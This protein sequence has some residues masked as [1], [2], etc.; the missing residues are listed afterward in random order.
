MT[1]PCAWELNCSFSTVR[2]M[3]P[4]NIQDIIMMINQAIADHLVTVTLMTPQFCRVGPIFQWSRGFICSL[5]MNPVSSCIL[6]GPGCSM[7]DKYHLIYKWRKLLLLR[8]WYTHIGELS[9]RY[10]MSSS[11]YRSPCS[12]LSPNYLIWQTQL[13]LAFSALCHLSQGPGSPIVFILVSTRSNWALLLRT[14]PCQAIFLIWIF[15]HSPSL[16]PDQNS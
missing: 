9:T 16:C 4:S 10:L 8:K 12:I 1:I 5:A 3:T 2:I 13:F 15:T 7:P 6:P 11:D 14:P